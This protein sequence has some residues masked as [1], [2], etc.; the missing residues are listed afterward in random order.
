MKKCDIRK[1][2]LKEERNLKGLRAIKVEG[3]KERLRQ[4]NDM[5]IIKN[6]IEK[7]KNEL[8]D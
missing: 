7:L 4:K 3:S 8:E 2:I 6:K 5:T 1:R